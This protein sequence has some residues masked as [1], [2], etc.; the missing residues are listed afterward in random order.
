VLTGE[1][2][3]TGEIENFYGTLDA[4]QWKSGIYAV[5]SRIGDSVIVQKIAVK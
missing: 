1:I 5:K 2:V 4:S 3:Y